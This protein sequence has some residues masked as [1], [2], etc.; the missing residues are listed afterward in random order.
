MLWCSIFLSRESMHIITLWGLITVTMLLTQLPLLLFDHPKFFHPLQFFLDFGSNSDRKFSWRMRMHYRLDVESHFNMMLS[1]WFSAAKTSLL[2]W[3]STASNKC[4]S[5]RWYCRPCVTSY[6]TVRG[7][8]VSP[9]PELRWSQNL[10]L[11]NAWMSC[12]LS[13][14]VSFDLRLIP[15]LVITSGFSDNTIAE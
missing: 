14:I 8:L 1:K 4:H 6:C 7:Y 13:S 3:V 15:L 10:H 11:S 5:E 2:I 12:S 9:H